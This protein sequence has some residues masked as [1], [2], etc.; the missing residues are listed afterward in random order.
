MASMANVLEI[1]RE[2]GEATHQRIR[3][4]DPS[5]TSLKIW[6]CKVKDLSLLAKLTWL[7]ELEIADWPH[8]S[9]DVMRHMLSL[10]RLSIHH[11]P[12]I[13]DLNS[14][15][16]LTSLE[17]LSL[18]TLP[19]WDPGGKHMLFD[20]YEPIGRLTCLEEL[21]LHGIMVSRLGLRPLASLVR[22]QSLS[23]D[24][25]HPIEDYAFLATKLP[26]V[27]DALGPLWQNP[28]IRCEKCASVIQYFRGV[29]KPRAR[30]YTCPNCNPNLVA[31]H[32]EAYES[33]RKLF[34]Q[35]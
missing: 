8:D 14:L 33:A 4:I 22:L 30:R 6:F 3:G 15:G 13:R 17:S 25:Q 20:S 19:S 16:T 10:R 32:V 11:F 31:R 29:T 12:K 24:T 9:F 7:Q 2:G 21:Q 34:T 23:I 27:T 1:I 28:H 5:T 35:A 18:Q 26:A